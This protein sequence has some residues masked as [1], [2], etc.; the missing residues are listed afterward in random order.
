VVESPVCRVVIDWLLGV[1][2]GRLT[3]VFVVIAYFI[4]SYGKFSRFLSAWKS[5]LTSEQLTLTARLWIARE[6]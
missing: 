4:V 6:L 1:F 3:A 5:S 2:D